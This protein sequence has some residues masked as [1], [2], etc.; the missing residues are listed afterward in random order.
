MISESQVQ[1][2]LDQFHTKMKIF[3]ILYRDDRG[4]KIAEHTL[5]YKFK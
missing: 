5:S 3:G 2:F 1:S 4:K